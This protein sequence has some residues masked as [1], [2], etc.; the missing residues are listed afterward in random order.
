MLVVFAVEAAIG[1]SL[2]IFIAAPVLP[3][4]TA[5]KAVSDAQSV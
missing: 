2:L 4:L 5:V 1:R 3:D